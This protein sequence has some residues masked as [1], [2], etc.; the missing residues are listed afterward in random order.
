MHEEHRRFASQV[1]DL[2]ADHGAGL[3]T[4]LEQL[5][6]AAVTILYGEKPTPAVEE[7]AT[8][9]LELYNWPTKENWLRLSDA[10]QAVEQ[11]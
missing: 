3:D 4:Y 11:S 8:V 10:S 7:L 9:A 2:L 1:W 6:A 5:R